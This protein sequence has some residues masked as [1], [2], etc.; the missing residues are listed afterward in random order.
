M[1]RNRADRIRHTVGFE[2][3]G[4]VLLTGLGSWLLG[5]DMQHFGALAVVFSLLAMVWNYYYNRLF[6]QWLLR[7]RGTSIKRQRDRIIHALL[8]EGGL[9]FITLP[10]IAW[11]MQVSL[12]Q[13]LVMDV[14]MAVFYLV[15]A[16]LYNLA[17]DRV[18]PVSVAAVL[19]PD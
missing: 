4:L 13:A 17:Y 6:D 10:L 9:L 18:F 11:W 8:F 5:L 2:L 3:V 12:W 14:G 19:S 16:Y 15:F 1:M 7:H